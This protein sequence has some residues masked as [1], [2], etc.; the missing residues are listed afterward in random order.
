MS[1]VQENAIGVGITKYISLS[2]YAERDNA[3]QKPAAVDLDGDATPTIPLARAGP[4]CVTG[5]EIFAGC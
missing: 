1:N 4:I 3:S 2:G 5:A